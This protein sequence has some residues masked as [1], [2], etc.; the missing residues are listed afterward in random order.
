MGAQRQIL[1]PGTL[2]KNGQ[3]TL[4]WSTDGWLAWSTPA[5]YNMDGE[6]WEQTLFV[7]SADD[8]GEPVALQLSADVRRT[9]YQ[10]IDWVPHSRLILAGRGLMANSLWVDGVPL[11]TINADSGEVRDLGVIMLLT[12][13]AYAWQPGQQPLL[14]MAEGAGRFLTSNKQLIVLDI[15]TG[16]SDRLTPKDQSVFEPV[17]SPDGKWLAYAANPARPDWQDNGEDM[18]R[19]L[20]GRAIYIVDAQN[21]DSGSRRPLTQPGA[22][23]DGWPSWSSDG[24]HLL[25]TR[26]TGNNVEIHRVSVDGQQDEVL[27]D[28][29]D[30]PPCFYSGCRWFQFMSYQ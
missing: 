29:L 3:A 2:S 26:Q 8:D 14:A 18:E 25:Y 7:K 15:A 1:P 28:G 23:I 19:G 13:E 30:D 27:V 12:R 20:S 16:S 22:G 9:Y 21:P 6:N 11:V 4:R 17:W 24:T 5:G 10:L